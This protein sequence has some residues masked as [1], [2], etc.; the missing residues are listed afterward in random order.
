MPSVSFSLARVAFSMRY[1][2]PNVAV[3]MLPVI[4][5]GMSCLIQ[6]GP[7]AYRALYSGKAAGDFPV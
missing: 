5:A 7:I 3:A 4:A 1:G 2:M 6:S